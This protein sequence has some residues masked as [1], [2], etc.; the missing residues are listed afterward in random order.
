MESVPGAREPGRV[1]G[2][3]GPESQ[4]VP[5]AEICRVRTED[6]VA[7]SRGNRRRGRVAPFLQGLVTEESK[8]SLQYTP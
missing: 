2:D 7:R 6:K 1:G 8:E 5:G 3:V 4:V